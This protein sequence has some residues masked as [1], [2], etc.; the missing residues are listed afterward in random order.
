[1]IAHL[2]ECE[3]SASVEQEAASAVGAPL[4]D[5]SVY[6]GSYTYSRMPSSVACWMP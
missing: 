5:A 2:A 3:E 1:M 6:A 4:P